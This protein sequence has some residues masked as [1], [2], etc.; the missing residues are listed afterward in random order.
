MRNDLNHQIEEELILPPRDVRNSERLTLTARLL[1]SLLADGDLPI[2]VDQ[3]VAPSPS[4]HWIV[5]QEV[6]AAT[7]RQGQRLN[8][9]DTGCRGSTVLFDER[10]M[11]LALADAALV[12]IGRNL[13]GASQVW[14]HLN[15]VFSSQPGAMLTLD[16]RIRA[17]VVAPCLGRSAR[18]KSS[19]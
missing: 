3:T 11:R 12:I 5:G 16:A 13:A 17:G 4:P 8:A 19:L 7:R 6:Q 2:Q 10:S 18:K 1:M 9:G 14:E 15:S